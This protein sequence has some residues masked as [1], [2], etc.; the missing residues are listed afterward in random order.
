MN[1]NESCD[2]NCDTCRRSIIC[3]TKDKFYSL[4]EIST[5]RITNWSSVISGKKIKSNRIL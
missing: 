2:Y 5:G 3:E 1:K 4:G